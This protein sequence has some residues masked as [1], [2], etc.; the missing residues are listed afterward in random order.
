VAIAALVVAAGCGGTPGASPSS[1]SPASEGA[2]K[3]S[4]FDSL[5]PVNLTIWSYDNQDPGLEPVLKELSSDFEKQYPNVKITMVFK[6]FN[7]LVNIVPRALASSDGPDITEGNQ[8]YQTDAQLV[9]AGLILPL[10]PYIKAYGWDKWYSPSTWSI[11]QWSNDGKTFGQGPKWGVAQTGQN[12]NIYVNT[13]K[14]QELGFDPNAMPTTF[15]DFNQMLADVRAKLPKDQPV[16][17]AGNQEG[18][19]FIHMFG[20]IQAAYVAPQDARDWIMHVPGSS[21]DTPETVKALTTLQ[22]WSTNGYLNDDYNA[23][24]N[25][26]SAAEF[27]KGKGVFWIGGNW[28]SAIIGQGL[29]TDNVKVMPF[30]P[31]ESGVTAGIGSTSGPWH[32]SSKTKYPDVAAAWLNYIIGSPKAQQLMFGQQQIPSVAGATAPST[33][34]YLGQV[35]DAWQKVEGDDGLMLYTDWASPTMY[36]TLASNFQK[37]MADKTSPQ[38]MAT[39]VQADWT[40][41]DD[42]LK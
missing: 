21:W 35:A 36:Q 22:S 30:P 2:V 17:E 4:G 33:E 24:K 41:F 19:G 42:T 10:D 5:G 8:G 23:I 39:A 37:L 6:D 40:K 12:V 25:D 7:S 18:Y 31:G 13:K 26:A 20:G 34:P 28:D 27:A 16:I 15:D 32:I 3:T 29:G 9:K 38:D 11:F 14:L 1:N